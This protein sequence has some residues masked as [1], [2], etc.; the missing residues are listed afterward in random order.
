MKSNHFN[1]TVVAKTGKGILDLINSKES[2]YVDSD[3]L[4]SSNEGKFLFNAWKSLLGHSKFTENDNFFQ[5]GGNSLK[6]VQLVSR[7]SNYFSVSLQLTDIFLYP[8]ISE[9]VTIILASEQ[10][11]S[12]PPIIISPRLSHIPLS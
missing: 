2:S 4:P 12:F 11:R 5:I 3:L 1:K 8:T 6:A 9:Q 10:K 7:I